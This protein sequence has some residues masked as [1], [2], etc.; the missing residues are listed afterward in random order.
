MNANEVMTY[1]AQNTEFKPINISV[2]GKGAS[3]CV[4]KVGL[5]KEP[6]AVAVKCSNNAELL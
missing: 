1:I 3:A 2:A 4:Y 6:Y 5:E